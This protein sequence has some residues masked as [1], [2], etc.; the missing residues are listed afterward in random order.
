M[1]EFTL[2]GI[3]AMFLL[4]SIFEVSRG[5]WNYHALAYAVNAGARYAAVH[6]ASCSQ[7]GYAC[8]ITV[9][10]VA[11]KIASAA[12]GMPP[13]LLNATLTSDTGAISCNP[14][15]TCQSGATSATTWPPSPNNAPGQEILVK[16]TYTFR[17]AIAIF[18]PG[19]RPNQFG[20]A[21]LGAESRQV[22]QF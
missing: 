19:S 8:G 16:A 7:P 11:D 17:S 5:M 15:N 20:V 3:P 6:G 14:L 22:I 1:V 12:I 21:T 4:V 13:N 9:K 18:W 2:V 10:D